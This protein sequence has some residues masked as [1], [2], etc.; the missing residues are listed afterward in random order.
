M[1]TLETWLKKYLPKVMMAATA[2]T[3]VT[4]ALPDLL[5]QHQRQATLQVAKVVDIIAPEAARAHRVLHVIN[6]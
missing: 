2:A 3:I 1:A 5:I 4:T 6:F